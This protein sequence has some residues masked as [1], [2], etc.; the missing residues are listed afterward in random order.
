MTTTLAI[1]PG[2]KKSGWLLFEPADVLGGLK[3]IN[4]GINTNGKLRRWFDSDC[5]A[6]QLIIETPNPQGMAMAAETMD[7]LIEIGRFVQVWEFANCEKGHWSHV[8]RQDV[9]LHLCGQARAKDKNVRQALI[10]RF[11]GNTVAIG[12]VKC[13]RCH[14]KGWCGRGRPVCEEC[15][16]Q[17]WDS[18]P[19]PLKGVTSHVWPALALACWWVDVGVNQPMCHQITTGHGR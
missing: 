19:G 1:D 13:P 12:G 11:G 6:E 3:L 17:G 10:D 16:G 4:F 9:K 15:G 5:A 2:N 7:T 8:F 14:G 18:S